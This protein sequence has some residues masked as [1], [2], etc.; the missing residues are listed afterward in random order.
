MDKVVCVVGPMR[1][2]PGVLFRA[3]Q[4]LAALFPGMYSSCAWLPPSARRICPEGPAHS[5]FF[6]G[7]PAESQHKACRPR[8][9]AGTLLF[10]RFFAGDHRQRLRY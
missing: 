3:V 9:G 6:A 8:S 5:S 4:S 1:P 2:V 10:C 7:K